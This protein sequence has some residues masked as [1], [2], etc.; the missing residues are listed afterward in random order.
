MTDQADP[1]LDLEP[2]ARQTLL[3]LAPYTWFRIFKYSVYMLLCYN[4]L[5]F[6]QQDFQASNQTFSNGI[7]WENL[8]AAFSAT[9]DTAA[10]VVLLLMFE[11]ETAVIPDHILRSGAR[12]LLLAIS[13]IC[14]FFIIY[15]FYGYW[16]KLGM[17]SSHVPFEIADV[18]SLIGT[19]R[20]YIITLDE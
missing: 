4:T 14:Y 19:P 5:L 2:E 1:S 18:C 3:G 16:I 6:F 7:S 8:V 9:I 20:H 13:S 12:W 17:I 15:A 11:L 10:W